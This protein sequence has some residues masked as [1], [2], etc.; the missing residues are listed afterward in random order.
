MRGAIQ[1]T[2]VCWNFTAL[3]G[4]LGIQ[5]PL[6]SARATESGSHQVRPNKGNAQQCHKLEVPNLGS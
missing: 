1:S 5:M 2:G 3:E 6:L 4:K